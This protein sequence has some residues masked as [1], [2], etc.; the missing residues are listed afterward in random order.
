MARVAGFHQDSQRVPGRGLGHHSGPTVAYTE[1]YGG[2]RLVEASE[3]V[4]DLMTVVG[5]LRAAALPPRDSLAFMTEI[6][7]DLDDR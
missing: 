1:C 3:E 5:M 6:R 2:G 4:A 7:R